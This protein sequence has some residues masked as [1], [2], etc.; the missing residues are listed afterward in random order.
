VRDWVASFH[1]APAA[2]HSAMRF[3][4]H[5]Y[6]AEPEEMG[7]ADIAHE[8]RVQHAG[9]GNFRIHAG[10]DVVIQHLASGLDVRLNTAVTHIDWGERPSGGSS[11]GVVVHTAASQALRASAVIV[12]VPLPVLQQDALTFDPPLPE[13]KRHAI[14]ALR[15]GPVVKLHLLFRER[16]WP[17]DTSIFS[18]S[19]DMPVWWPP[20]FG[21]E[22]SED[23]PPH[24]LTAFVGAKRALALDAMTNEAVADHA[25]NALCQMFT[26]APHGEVGAQPEYVSDLPRRTFIKLERVSWQTDP[27]ARGGYTFVPTGAYGARQAL[28]EPVGG[29][30]FFAGE[31]TVFDSNPA[32][33]HGALESG[34]RAAR[35]VMRD[36]VQVTR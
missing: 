3:M 29:R 4:A 8:A 24:V 16:F 27:W 15:M 26:R 10:Y 35:E 7:V 18:G 14:Q 28:A 34:W 23:Q 1:L 25:L 33:V 21:R 9:S 13:A 12:T 19:G 17:D 22:R 32:T 31:A 2:G 5:P 30:V 36:L 11:D 20:A 6:L